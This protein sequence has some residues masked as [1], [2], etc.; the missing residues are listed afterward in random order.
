MPTRLAQWLPFKGRMRGVDLGMHVS[1]FPLG[2]SIIHKSVLPYLAGRIKPLCK[3]KAQQST[4]FC[5]WRSTGHLPGRKNLRRGWPTSACRMTGRWDSPGGSRRASPPHSGCAWWWARTAPG[6]GG[7]RKA[8]GEATRRALDN[9]V[10]HGT[11]WE[12]LILPKSCRNQIKRRS[13]PLSYPDIYLKRHW[14]VDP[15]ARSFSH[16]RA[17]AERRQIK[18]NLLRLMSG[19]KHLHF[20]ARKKLSVSTEDSLTHQV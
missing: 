18:M 8:A 6:G 11:H 10:R 13:S 2:A 17:A 9:P 19:L 4:T 14:Y 7:G 12:L 15:T 3:A 5:C 1:L 16:G 20:K